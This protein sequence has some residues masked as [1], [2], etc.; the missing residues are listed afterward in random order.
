[1]DDSGGMMVNKLDLK[2]DTGEFESYWVPHSYD[3]C[4]I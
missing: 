1:M 3:L 2:T 4:N